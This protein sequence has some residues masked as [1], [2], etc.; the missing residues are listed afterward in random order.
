VGDVIVFS[1]FAAYNGNETELSSLLKIQKEEVAAKTGDFSYQITEIT[2]YEPA[3]LD[4]KLFD[5]VMGE[6]VVSSEEEFRAKVRETLEA[7]FAIDSDYKFMTDLRK[8]LTERIGTLEYPTEMLKR[9]MRLNNPDKGEEFVENNF[10]KSLE[11]LTW[12][13]IK[14]Q[15]SDQF[16]V[17]INHDDVLETA[18]VVTRIQFAQYGMTNIPDEVIANYAGEMLKNKQQAEGLV[19]RAVENKIAVAAKAL[20]KLNEKEMT[21]DEFNKSFQN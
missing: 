16:D 13:L 12:H 15:L 5:Q 18:K 1:P 14:E 6:G 2:R 3:A 11:E 19:N 8:Y 7:Q 17:K 4:Q 20:V 10:D 9:I 21:L